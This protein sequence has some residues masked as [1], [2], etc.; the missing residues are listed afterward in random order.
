MRLTTGSRLGPYEIVAPIGAGGMGEVFKA[1]DTRLDRLVAIKVLPAEFADNVQL[2]LRLEREAKMISQLNHPHI[3]A[4]YDVGDGYL[5]MELLEG[6]SLADK[7]AKGRLP[8]EQVLRYGIEIADALEKA[9]RAGVV[10]RDLKPGNIMI[11]KSGAKLLDFGL[12]K[13]TTFSEQEEAT[14]RRPLTEQ[15]SLLGTLQYMAPELIEGGVADQRSDLFA[16][17]AVLYE[18]ATGRRAFEGK[19]KGSIIAS[20]LTAEAPVISAIHTVPAAFE[21]VVR[22]CLQK[23]PEDR[24]QSAHD[25]RLELQWMQQSAAEMQSQIVSRR[26]WSALLLLLVAVI[27]SALAAA[28][29]V[30]F[31]FRNEPR[32]V[33]QTTIN[34][35][36][37]VHLNLDQGPIAL[38][39]DGARL[40]FVATGDG[41]TL[42]WVRP[43]DS[44]SGQPLAGTDGASYPFWSFDSRLIAF[45]AD[46]KLKKIDPNGGTPEIL[47]G[48]ATGRGGAWNRNGVILFS[49]STGDAILRVSAA[50]GPATAVTRLDEARGEFSHR[51]PRFLPDGRHFLYLALAGSVAASLSWTNG[52]RICVG[53]LDSAE[54]SKG[55]VA[56]NSNAAYVKPGFLLYVREGS[57]RAQRFD[58][59]SG[60]VS[61]EPM[62]IVDQIQYNTGPGV[63][64]YSATDDGLLS[65]VAGA[66]AGKSVLT[67]FDR[68]GK[69]TG[70]VGAP[71]NFWD[72]RLSHD[73]KRVAVS[74]NDTRGTGDIWLYD[75][76]RPLQTRLTFDPAD[77]QAPVWDHDD[78]HIIFSSYR[79]PANVFRKLTAGS[80]NDELLVASNLRKI[81]SDSSRDGIV[82]FD[83]QSPRTRWDLIAYSI[84]DKKQMPFAATSFNEVGGVFSSDGRWVAYV[85]D[86][87]GTNE[88]YVA[89]F[90]PSSGKWQVSSGGGVM[91]R[92]AHTGQEIFYFTPQGSTLMVAPIHL[93]DAV[94]VEAPRPLFAVRTRYFAGI[95]R[96]QYDVAPDDQRFL[97]NVTSEEQAQT[98][99]TLYQN[100]IA[101]VVK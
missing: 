76:L 21:R 26:P 2:R 96:T 43:L 51:W 63:A 71:A 7:L 60:T 50:G 91:P 41:K 64:N 88:V 45:F 93:G 37:N 65:F 56:A 85:S 70:T 52:S 25:V 58:I 3:C 94:E 9:H 44:P 54:P 62:P 68:R 73:G 95:V 47:A 89:R 23:D 92:W 4:L 100:W 28:S 99:L 46:G 36:A 72:P 20:I 16:F 79:G 5:I 57:L 61:G 69:P 78:S 82:L 86:E 74:V 38:S 18:M 1:R 11:T 10:H 19:S 67:W 15:G 48:A 27:I 59:A 75:V 17:G 35:P 98:P 8:F 77:D 30:Y 55:I 87:S 90:P 12:A 66:G 97:I 22:T 42:L 101:K 13:P 84:A 31:R 49:P 29:V 53:S 14:Q 40:A 34:L 83:Q 6:E 32:Q 39:P 80:G 33:F 24:F 81:V